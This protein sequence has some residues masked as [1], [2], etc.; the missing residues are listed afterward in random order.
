MVVIAPVYGV[1]AMKKILVHKRIKGFIRVEEGFLIT[2]SWRLPL[3][4]TAENIIKFVCEN[5]W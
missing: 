3:C 5:H 1:N 2:M 4:R